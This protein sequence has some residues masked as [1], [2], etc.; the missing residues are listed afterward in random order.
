MGIKEPILKTS[1]DELSE[2]KF[3]H[4]QA[5]FRQELPN[6]LSSIEQLWTK[7]VK[8]KNNE[9]DLKIITHLILH[10]ADTAGTYG[11]DEVSYIARKCYLTFKPFQ[12]RD[13]PVIVNAKITESLDDWFMRLSVA[14]NEWLSNDTPIRKSKKIKSSRK[15]KTVY[16][17]LGDDVFSSELTPQVEKNNCNIQRFN[18]LSE[19]KTACENKNPMAII[20]D[21]DFVDGDIAGVTAVEYLK[22]QVNACP[23]VIFVSDENDVNYRLKIARAGVDRYFCRPTKVNKI[24]QTLMGLNSELDNIPYRVLIVDDDLILLECYSIVLMESDMVVLSESKPLEAF[25]AIEKFLP[26]VIVLDMYMPECSGKELVSMIRQ[27]DRWALIPIIFLSREQDINNQLQAIEFGAD[28]F[29]VKP[30]NTN[31]LVATINASAKRARKNVK[32]NFELK[33]SL[34]ENKYQLITL[35]QHAIVGITDVG[36]R[37][38]HVNDKLCEIS[39]YSREE[40]LGQNHRILKS[41]HH[42]NDFFKKLWDTISSGKVWHGVICNK[43]KNGSEYWV[44]STIVPFLD[45]KGKP[46]KYVSVRTDITNLRVSEDRLSRSQKFANIGTWDWDIISGELYW[47][48]RIWSLFGFNK[49]NT[50]ATYDNFIEAVHPDDRELVINTVTDCNENGNAYDIEHRVVWPDGTIHWLHESGDV[51]RN[52]SG[53]PIHMLGVVR[54]ITLFKTT[55]Q[56]MMVAREEAEKANLAKSKFLSSMSHELRTPMNAIMGFSQLLKISKIEPLTE[57]QAV[58]VEEIMVAG[59]HLMNLIDEVLD[60]SKIE[61]GHLEISR[62]NVNVNSVIKES[63]QLIIPVAQSRGIEIVIICNDKTIGLNQL[64]DETYFAYTDKTKFKQII[65]NL[66]SNAAKY[67]SEDGKITLDYNKVE[68]GLLRVS[69]TDTGNGLSFK[70]QEQLFTAFN[71]LGLEQT[72]V[73]GSGIGLVITKKIVEFMDGKIGV[74]SKEGEGSTFW[75]ELPIHSDAGVEK[76]KD[77]QK[78][79]DVEDNNIRKRSEKRSVLYIEDN[80]A[81]LRLVEQILECIPYINM[82]SAPEPLLGLELAGE[83]IPDLILLDINLPG[84]DGYQVLEK[85]RSQESTKDIPVVAISA[86]AMPRDIEKGK[87]AGFDGYITK[88]VNVKELLG[89]VEGKL[90]KA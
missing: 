62:S 43:A 64:D 53:K 88:P 65:L 30:I 69:V 35:D 16:S 51:V 3:L 85:L 46:Y 80:P 33:K 60:L 12:G 11:T 68:E 76:I 29:L 6:K 9:D 1:N 17:L 13:Y 31:K 77:E 44:N 37:I 39:G 47:S 22:K 61:T 59:K 67:N 66:L 27:D 15:E 4:L 41:E 49:K 84:I 79:K 34:R 8:N 55:E 86:N 72:E 71:R 57:L 63:L 14:S 56:E 2:S 42:S 5:E 21:S 10:L 36:G 82:W 81:N 70:Q 87:K 20:V 45:E 23:P 90:E 89:E 26:D 74:N 52:S 50:D 54:D 78:A 24:I 73:E 19:I 32:L 48:D 38:I 75:F 58:N 18:T 40:L 28:D 83:H 7:I 25:D